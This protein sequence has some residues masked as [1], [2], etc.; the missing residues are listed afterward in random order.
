MKER[1]KK[2]REEK[3]IFI[4]SSGRTKFLLFCYEL[5]IFDH[6]IRVVSARFLHSKVAFVPFVMN[7]YFLGKVEWGRSAI[8]KDEMYMHW[9]FYGVGSSHLRNA[10]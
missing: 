9:G 6:L 1:R 8:S 5:P 3:V 10:S 7:K 4:I 2:G